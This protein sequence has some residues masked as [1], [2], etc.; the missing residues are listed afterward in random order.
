MF[1][2]IHGLDISLL[3]P[4]QQ[5]LKMHN[6]RANYH[7]MIWKQA[8]IAQPDFSEPSCYGWTKSDNG[9]VSI[10]WCTDLFPQQLVDILYEKHTTN[11]EKRATDDDYQEEDAEEDQPGEKDSLNSDSNSSDEDE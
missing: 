9:I 6:L 2:S 3:P 10:N 7:A 4:C 1:S 11:E 5:A 8:H